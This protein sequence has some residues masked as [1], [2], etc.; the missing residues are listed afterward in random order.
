MASSAKW[1][2]GPVAM[3]VMSCY[4]VFRIGAGSATVQ[5]DFRAIAR[6]DQGRLAQQEVSPADLA[7]RGAPVLKG[8]QQWDVLPYFM[9]ATAAVVA[10][11]LIASRSDNRFMVGYVLY[12]LIAI[13]WVVVPNVAAYRFKR[14]VPF[15]TL[16]FTV[17][18]L[19]RRLQF[20]AAV[21]AA[22]LVILLIHLALYPWPS[23]G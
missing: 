11:A 6:T 1:Q 15:T 8:R 7:N 19:S 20:V 14:D 10:T 23:R 17:R 13:V 4:S 5:A 9:F 18:C 2:P 22:L 16:F 3:I 21:I 12:S